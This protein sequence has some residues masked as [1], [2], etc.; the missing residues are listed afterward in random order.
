MATHKRKK[1]ICKRTQKQ[2]RANQKAKAESQQSPKVLLREVQKDSLS[3]KILEPSLLKLLQ[4]ETNLEWIDDLTQ[5]QFTQITEDVQT[6]EV[7]QDAI[8]EDDLLW[9]DFF[10]KIVDTDKYAYNENEIT[11]H[12]N[13]KWNMTF[14]G[15]IYE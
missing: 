3:N 12:L 4:L 8:G 10:I 14:E 13:L 2:L 9:A 7:A 6:G 11:Q 5:S 1:R 15:R